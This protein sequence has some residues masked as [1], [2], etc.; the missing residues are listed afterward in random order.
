MITLEE[1]TGF[2]WDQGNAV[3]NWTRHE[4]TQAEIEQIFLNQPLLL[5]ADPGHSRSENRFHA[6]GKTNDD[7]RLH[8]S[9]TFRRAGTL[10]RV[11]SARPMHRK[12]RLRYAQET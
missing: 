12:E 3:K 2:D 6:L 8:V 1:V 11:I 10:I 4:V 5:L 7:R 9:F